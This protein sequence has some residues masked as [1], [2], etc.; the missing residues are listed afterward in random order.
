MPAFRAE[1]QHSAGGARGQ[2]RSHHA[3]PESFIANLAIFH[4]EPVDF[5]QAKP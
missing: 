4:S 3:F 2:C 5:S 1:R